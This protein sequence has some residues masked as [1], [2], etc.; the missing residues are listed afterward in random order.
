[1][2]FF[3][4]IFVTIFL[5]F[6]IVNTH[7]QEIVDLDSVD[8]SQHLD[9]DLPLPNQ[10]FKKSIIVNLDNSD[11]LRILPVRNELQEAFSKKKKLV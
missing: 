9:I 2:K 1:M 4:F 6:G 3:K 10:F 5:V 8:N 11:E 7:E